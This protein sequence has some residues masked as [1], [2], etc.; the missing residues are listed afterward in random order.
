[1]LCIK[2]TV[3]ECWL[4]MQLD[5]WKKNQEADYKARCKMLANWEKRLSDLQRKLSDREASCK[6]KK[7]GTIFV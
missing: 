3:F 1:M 2:A 5:E 4:P 6:A 7:V